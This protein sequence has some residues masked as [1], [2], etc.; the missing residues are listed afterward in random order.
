MLNCIC[1]YSFSLLFRSIRSIRQGTAFYAA[2]K[3]SPVP[4]G[5]R[6]VRAENIGNTLSKRVEERKISDVFRMKTEA[7]RHK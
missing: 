2:L 6:K 3:R 4:C 5:I 1:L 7:D